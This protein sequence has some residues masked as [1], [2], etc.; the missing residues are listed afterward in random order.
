MVRLVITLSVMFYCLTII[1]PGIAE[2]SW[3][4]A[5]QI[6]QTLA[7]TI[8]MGNMLE[9]PKEGAW[10]LTLK[11]S[12]FP[13]IAEAG[14]TAVRIPVSWG[15]HTEEKEPYKIDPEFMARVKRAVNAALDAKLSV[16]LNIHHDPSINEK[17]EEGW[18][19]LQAMWRQIASEFSGSPDTLVFELLNEP[20][21][22]LNAE[23]WMKMYPE[24]LTLVRKTNPK[25]VV[26]IG[27]P[28]WNSVHDLPKLKLPEDDHQIIAT[29][30][31]YLPFEFTHQG[32]EWSSE[33]VRNLKRE[34]T[35]SKEERAAIDDHFRAAAEWGK[36]NH[37]PLFL[38]EFGAYSKGDLPSRVRWTHFVVET[39]EKY[40]IS[41]GYWEFAAGFGI[42]DPKAEKW[43]PELRDALLNG[44]GDLRNE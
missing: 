20:H 15:Y 34:W 21:E 13:I 5:E 10:G 26:M 9:P 33:H 44:T 29:F 19:R 36:A 30:H 41:W 18:P 7:K 38:G 31:Y 42:Y 28:N 11:E 35:G 22:K 27:G 1:S 4:N 23:R 40:H 2:D 37:R 16:I 24:L 8:N 32:A 43:R 25:R 17:P 12:Y 39:A 6:N 14:F 3:R